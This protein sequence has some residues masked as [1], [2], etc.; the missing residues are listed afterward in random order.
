MVSIPQT[1]PWCGSENLIRTI[2]EKDPFN[3]MVI[4]NTC[5]RVAG[6]DAGDTD[7][8]RPP[9]SGIPA[10]VTEKTI[11]L[12]LNSGKLQGI[13]YY[14]SEVSKLPGKQTDILK[15]KEDVEALLYA[16]GLTNAVKK[17][18]RNGC[19]VALI[20]ILLIIASIVYFFTRR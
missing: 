7:G 20:V 8:I 14:Y 16:R 9:V 6:S 19:V 11:Q 15:A 10:A 12:C 18:N 3:I 17:P 4:C 1:C 5:Q 2:P 13:R